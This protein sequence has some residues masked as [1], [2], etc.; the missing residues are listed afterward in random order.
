MKNWPKRRAILG[1][2]GLQWP[3]MLGVGHDT[4]K[5]HLHNIGTI[6]VQQGIPVI[7]GRELWNGLELANDGMHLRWE[8]RA[9]FK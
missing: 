8:L 1:A 4:L 2:E 6:L 7:H 5:D 3:F 9:V